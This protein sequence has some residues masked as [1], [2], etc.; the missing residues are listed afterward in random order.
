MNESTN[1]KRDFSIKNDHPWQIYSLFSVYDTKR[2]IIC[3]K[4]KDRL[5]KYWKKIQINHM[6]KPSICQT[7]PSDL[8]SVD[9]A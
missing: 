8:I 7:Q 6:H 1:T 3:L 5:L 2:T 9:Y 4:T